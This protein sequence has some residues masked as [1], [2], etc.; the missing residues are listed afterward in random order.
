MRPSTFTLSYLPNFHLFCYF[1]YILGPS[2][3]LGLG[4]SLE[5]T[6]KVL[7]PCSKGT[8]SIISPK[9]WETTKLRKYGEFAFC[10]S[11][12]AP[13][14]YKSSWSTWLTSLST[15]QNGGG[16]RY[17]EE[18]PLNARKFAARVK[19]NVEDWNFD[20]VDFFNWVRHAPR[21]KCR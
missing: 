7:T 13:F 16:D 14:I 18:I 5:S 4:E 11:Q 2:R 17:L 8:S 3:W 21:I 19:K 9:V 12:T 6:D 20:G 10:D 1:I 15:W